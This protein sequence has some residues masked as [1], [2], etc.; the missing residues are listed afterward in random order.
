M[1]IARNVP[2]GLIVFHRMI[3]VALLTPMVSSEDVFR[4]ENQQEENEFHH[5]LFFPMENI[6]FYDGARRMAC[7]IGLG[8]HTDT[9]SLIT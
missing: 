9:L 2:F 5:L 6:K 1:K 8:T 4:R 3:I 7:L